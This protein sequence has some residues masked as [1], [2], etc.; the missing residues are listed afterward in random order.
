MQALLSTTLRSCGRA[1][2]VGSG[3][4]LRGGALV[5]GHSC[6]RPASLGGLLSGKGAESSQV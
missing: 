1:A 6:L 3:Q 5:G 4:Q 2:Q